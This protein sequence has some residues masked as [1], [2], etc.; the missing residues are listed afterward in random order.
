MA[1]TIDDLFASAMQQQK[2]GKIDQAEASLRKIL[3]L[4]PNH[5]VA[6][7]GMGVLHYL[8]GR[9][10]SALW[11]VRSAITNSPKDV[12]YHHNLGRMLHEMKRLEEA[13][14]ALQTAIDLKPD[15]VE[16]INRLGNIYQ[17]MG[18]I[19]QAVEC[20]RKNTPL[21]PS[22]PN[23]F[24]NYAN[25]L[26]DQH[27]L[28]AAIAAYRTA[29]SLNPKFADAYHNLGLVYQLYCRPDD[30][31]DAYQ[32]A[33]EIQPNRADSCVNLGNALK[34]SG[35][36]EEGLACYQR[37][38]DLN[39][40]L[41]GAHSARLFSLYYHPDSDTNRILSEFRAWSR[42]FAEPLRA[43]ILPHLND[44]SP[45]RKLRIGYVSPDFRDHCQSFFTVPLLSN[46]DRKEFE[47]YCYSSV[48]KPDGY[49]VRIRSH[50]DVWRDVGHL[51]DAQ[52][53]QV[54]RADKI[55]ILVDLTMQMA[56]GRPMLFAR[57]PAPI[58]V[59]WLA[60]PG[61]TGLPTMDYRLSDPHLDPP[62]VNDAFYVEKTVQLPVCFWCYDPL[63]DEPAVNEL[64][65][66]KNGFITFGCLNSFVKVHDGLLELWSRVLKA[67]PTSRFLLLAPEGSARR[68]VLEKLD[69]DPGRIDFVSYLPR[70]LYLKSYSRIDL[71]LDTFPIN[72]HTTSFDS[73][74]MG[75]PVVTLYGQT[76][77]SRAGL[78]QN[79]LLGLKDDFVA[80]TP[81]QF[82]ELAVR[83][84]GDKQKLS[85]LRQSLRQRIAASPLM[86]GRRFASDVEAAFRA[87]WRNWCQSK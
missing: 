39:P 6:L 30:A 56:S 19:D 25:A 47:V 2:A 61:T 50:A 46:H 80:S 21:L 27:D 63:T 31:I 35:K 22:N 36:F 79:T 24:Y 60:Y 32:H 52:L 84:A 71:G 64:P 28:D 62:G 67:V 37:A 75:V 51:T 29:I 10:E 49:T 9:R 41:P 77:I 12:E 15:H 86:D 73:L 18:K 20:F 38:Q 17:E 65:A 69:V 53:T 16:A 76:A 72:G 85:D 70:P 8:T 23:V 43:E 44:R 40:Q 13:A 87:M 11:L 59:A 81:D 57:K 83:W 1:E 7:H 55:D 68:H 58:Q 48:T 45:D 26:K 14:A 82:V 54:I 42:R 78:C 74:W 66:L 4:H 33:L 34:D 3:E 5:P